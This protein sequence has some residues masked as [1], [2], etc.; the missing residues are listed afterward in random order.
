MEYTAAMSGWFLSLPALLPPPV[1]DVFFSIRAKQHEPR[2][3]RHSPGAG[4]ASTYWL[5]RFVILRLLGAFYAVAFLGSHQPDCALIG[6]YGLLPVG[7][8]Y[9]K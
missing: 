1:A 7:S 8:Y 6:A 5:T 9:N 3:L 4:G 2:I